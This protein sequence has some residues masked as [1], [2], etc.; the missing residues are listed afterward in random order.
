MGNEFRSNV[1]ACTRLVL[2]H[3]GLLQDDAHA[4]GN[5]TAT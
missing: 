3:N 4:L 1:A 5:L 2:H